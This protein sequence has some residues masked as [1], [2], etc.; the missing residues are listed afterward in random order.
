[1]HACTHIPSQKERERLGINSVQ[2]RTGRLVGLRASTLRLDRL[3]EGLAAA[4]LTVRLTVDVQERGSHSR[5]TARAAE[6]RL[7]K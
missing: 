2:I 7:L 3:R 1:M 5:T 6:A 4:G